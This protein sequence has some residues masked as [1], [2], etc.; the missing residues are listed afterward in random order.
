MFLVVL[1]NL[2][3]VIPEIG[4]ALPGR[5]KLA[6]AERPKRCKNIESSKNVETKKGKHALFAVWFIST[7]VLLKPLADAPLLTEGH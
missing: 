3:S 2:P 1:L 5:G 4:A 6:D 7:R